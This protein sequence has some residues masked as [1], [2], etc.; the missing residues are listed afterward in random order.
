MAD[1][2]YPQPPSHKKFDFGPI[3]IDSCFDSG[4]LYSA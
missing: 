1:S 4:N 3:T 2:N